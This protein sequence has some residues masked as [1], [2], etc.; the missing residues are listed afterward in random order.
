[1]CYVIFSAGYVLF[2]SSHGSLHEGSRSTYTHFK[3]IK[4]REL[5]L[6]ED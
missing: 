4:R 1:M 6:S 2:I 3:G 5:I